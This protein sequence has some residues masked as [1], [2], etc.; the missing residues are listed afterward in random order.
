[1]ERKKVV[2]KEVRQKE[3]MVEVGQS[4]ISDGS[5]TQFEEV[6][7]TPAR[8]LFVFSSFYLSIDAS[9]RCRNR[10]GVSLSLGH[11]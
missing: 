4:K 5:Q 3:S 9:K 1:M 10:L 6:V 7:L 2:I 8:V 11:K